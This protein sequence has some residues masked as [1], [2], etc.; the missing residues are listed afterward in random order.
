MLRKL[1]EPLQK[2][3]GFVG[4]SLTGITAVF[5][6]AG[7]LAERARLTML[8]LPSTTF[9]LQ[10]YLETGA[11]FL[12]FLP[13][14]LGMAFYYSVLGV[15][16]ALLNWLAGRPVVAVVL[17]LAAALSGILW[18]YVRRRRKAGRRAAYAGDAGEAEAGETASPP[19]EKPWFPARFVGD[20]LT[21]L[22]FVFLLVQFLGA[23]QLTQALEVSNL[24]F[25]PTLGADT[26]PHATFSIVKTETLKNWIVAGQAVQA[27]QYLGWLFLITLLT[28]WGLHFVL[29]LYRE[30]GL[31]NP[32][33]WQITWF[34]G[35][36]LLLLTQVTLLPI[37][38]G[39]LLTSNRFV[40]VTV[41]YAEAEAEDGA[42]PLED[43]LYLLHETGSGF[44]FYSSTLR[45]VWYVLRS[46]VRSIQHHRMVRILQ[47]ASTPP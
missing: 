28:G 18:V 27:A 40:E 42:R 15:L 16:S 36:L 31:Q 44:Y 2:L 20:H 30:S 12:A 5:T 8:G 19:G 25:E 39:I 29:K 22:L 9:D 41:V 14:Y 26:I 21:G 23:Y 33:F 47:P 37:N 38:Y 10:Q 4:A 35:S 46:D 24:L 34:A 6:A 13:L 1:S 32:R 7:F 43:P 45:K 11:R 17:L 3:F